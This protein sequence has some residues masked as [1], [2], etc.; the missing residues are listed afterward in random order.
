M[1]KRYQPEDLDIIL[2]ELQGSSA[3]A[4]VTVM[5]AIVEHG[6]E[7]AIESYLRKPANKEETA[8]LFRDPGLLGSFYEKIWAAYFLGF[9]GPMTRRD[10]GV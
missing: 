10:L 6:L 8:V 7:L 3:R 1:V 4:T 5:G 2:R 9:I